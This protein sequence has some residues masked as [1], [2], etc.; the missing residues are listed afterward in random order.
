[1]MPLIPKE[2]QEL[3]KEINKWRLFDKETFKFYFKPDTPEWVKTEDER[4]TK[5]YYS[6]SECF[7]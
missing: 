3:I 5:Q 2:D 6:F 1:M 4:I 7:G